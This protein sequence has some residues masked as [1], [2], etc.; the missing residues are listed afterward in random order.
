[1]CIFQ[2]MSTPTLALEP[3][4]TSTLAFIDSGLKDYRKLIE[5]L[6][7]GVRAIVLQGD[8]VEQITSTLLTNTC[9]ESVHLLA[10]GSPGCIRLGKTL[11]HVATIDRY[12]QDLQVW[13]FL[14]QLCDRHPSL[15]LYGSNIATGEQGKAF[16]TRLHFL[17]GAGILASSSHTGSGSMG[18]NWDLEQQIGPAS[19]RN[20]LKPEVM[21]SY[22]GL[23]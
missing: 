2:F 22:R 17:T 5:G 18:G 23:L 6:E 15:H 11:L 16:L 9:L 4:R 14:S 12:A 8:G 10:S 1:M 19:R 20:I 7:P 3:C 13:F 21:A